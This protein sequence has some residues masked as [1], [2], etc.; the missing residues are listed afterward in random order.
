[1]S[2]DRV[3]VSL[4]ELN[5]VVRLWR[6]ENKEDTNPYQYLFQHVHPLVIGA[7]DRAESLFIMLCKEILSYHMS[8]Q[9]KASEIAEALNSKYPT[10]RPRTLA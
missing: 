9:E 8:N 5:R 2:N 1:M 3:S 10:T 4:D 7:V 6:Q